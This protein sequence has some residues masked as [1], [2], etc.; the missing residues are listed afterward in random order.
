MTTDQ[1]LV[2]IVVPC[3]DKERYI[4]ATFDTLLGQTYDAVELVLVNDGST[5]ATRSIIAS[6]LPVF[7]Q[8]GY[9][10]HVLDQ[11]N[12]GVCTAARNGLAATTG[13]YV[14]MVDADDELEPDY[15]S[16]MASWLSEHPDVD[17]VICGGDE[18]SL[19]DGE[20]RHR[21]GPDP[22][23]R[24]DADAI[25]V[26]HFLLGE[27]V[28]QTVWVYM[29]RASYLQRCRVVESYDTRTRGSHEPSYVIPLLANEGTRHYIPRALYHFNDSGDGHSHAA[30]FEQARRFYGDYEQLCRAALGRLAPE[31]LARVEAD[32]VFE[33]LEFSMAYHL[34]RRAQWCGAAPHELAACRQRLVATA[35]R[36]LGA[37]RAEPTEATLGD[38]EALVAEVYATVFRRAPRTRAAGCG[39]A[40]L[41]RGQP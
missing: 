38:E 17:L 21:R 1:A 37:R 11:P 39:A 6:Y 8:R 30:V 13:D 32:S 2:S 25:G 7:E 26:N 23:V 41:D 29:V 22:R 18:F 12:L 24:I 14:C 28:R 5:D 27:V 19:V 34:F 33:V 16:T 36:V 20:R 3:F 15:V 9:R 35:T 4:G 10:V 31:V 40:P